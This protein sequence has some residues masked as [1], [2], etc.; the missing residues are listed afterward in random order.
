MSTRWVKGAVATVAVAVVALW[1]ASPYWTV[2]Q[3]REAAREGQAERFNAYVDYPKLRENLTGQVMQ[4][5][6][7]SAEAPKEGAGE[8]RS[9]SGFGRALGRAMAAGAVS[10]LVRPEVVM[11]AMQEGQLLPKKRPAE[12][13][14][15][16]GD[17]SAGQRG[18]ASPDP[19]QVTWWTERKG[20]N[21]VI[22]YARRG[23]EPD[24]K[25]MGLVLEQRGFASWQL[26]D[27]RLPQRQAEQGL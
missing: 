2:H 23:D 4:A 24:H 18:E 15:D 17:G 3:M 22:F 11:R 26:V 27:I 5:F 8:E 16:R 25:K 6:G 10:A 21:T 1:F 9:A 14:S 19:H 20:L 13:T 12:P 7:G